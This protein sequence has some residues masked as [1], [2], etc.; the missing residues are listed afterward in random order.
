MVKIPQKEK[1]KPR[2]RGGGRPRKHI[3]RDIQTD[4]SHLTKDFSCQKKVTGKNLTNF[5]FHEKTFNKVYKLYSITL[6]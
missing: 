2:G 4:N 1:G 5:I 3:D 6:M